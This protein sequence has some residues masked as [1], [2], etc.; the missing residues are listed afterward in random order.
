M[1]Y[2]KGDIFTDLSGNMWGQIMYGDEVIES[3]CTPLLRN[4]LMTEESK[5]KDMHNRLDWLLHH[6]NK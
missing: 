5:E 6:L 4:H 2:T 1:K 3:L